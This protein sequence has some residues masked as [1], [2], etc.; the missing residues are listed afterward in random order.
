MLNPHD[1]YAQ[2]AAT[3]EPYPH[4]RLMEVEQR[5]MI[6]LL[7]AVRGGVVL[8]AG[9]GTGRYADLLR[10]GGAARVLACDRSAD[11]LARIGGPGVFRADICALPL[12]AGSIDVITC[13]L[14]LP[15]IDDLAAAMAELSR[16]L[17][18]GGALVAS[19]LHPRGA[20]AGW[21]RTFETHDGL[22]EVRACWHSIADL[23]NACMRAGMAL[24]DTREPGL[25]DDP[26]PVALAFRAERAP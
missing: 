6:E 16:V 5:A 3:Y 22:R 1:A 25:D 24:V 15:D 7:P 9:C 14:V 10:G 20:A 17:R 4:N 23:R 19:T 2:W 18:P 21:R 13:G 11:M 8:D 12:A 26:G